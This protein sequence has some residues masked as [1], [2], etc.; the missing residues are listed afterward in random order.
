MTAIFV[1]VQRKL[2]EG[3]KVYSYRQYFSGNEDQMRKRYRNGRKIESSKGKKKR[4]LK[5]KRLK[6]KFL[7]FRKRLS[8]KRIW[9]SVFFFACRWTFLA[10]F[11]ACF[12]DQRRLVFMKSRG[13]GGEGGEVCIVLTLR[14]HLLKCNFTNMRIRQRINI[15]LH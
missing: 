10:L 3:V 15:A 8:I 6:L 7:W 13:G 2:E 12:Y 4:L 14:Y 5:N 1:F 11:G 9:N